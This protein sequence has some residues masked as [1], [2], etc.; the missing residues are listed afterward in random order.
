DPD[1]ERA[2]E[3][4]STIEHFLGKGE[5][6]A[7]V[8]PH[9]PLLAVLNRVNSGLIANLERRLT[10]LDASDRLSEVLEEFHVVR[11][12]IGFPPT[13]SPVGTLIVRQAV[14][15]VLSGQRWTSMTEE[16]RQLV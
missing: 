4:A 14:D 15:H 9:G 8:S 12:E 1:L 13:A 11:E 10:H 7:L 16:M 5:T 3:I 2:W 6:V